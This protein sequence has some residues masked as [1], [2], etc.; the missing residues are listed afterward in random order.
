MQHEIVSPEAWLAARK[1]HLAKEKEF[2]RLRDQLSRRAARSCPG[3]GSTSG[4]AFDGPDGRRTLP[5]LFDGRSQL[6]VYHFMLGPGWERGLQRAA[7]SSPTTST[8]RSCISRIATSRWSR[9]RARRWPRSRR[10]SSAWAGA[11]RGSLRY[12]SDFNAD[13]HVSFTQGASWPRGKVYYNYGMTEFPS[14]EAPGASVFYKDEDGAV[15]HTYSAYARG[16]D[17]LVGTYNWLD[18][19]PKGRD[20][21]ALPWTMAW[22]RH[23]DRYDVEPR[24]GIMSRAWRCRNRDLPNSSFGTSISRLP[25]GPR[26]IVSRIQL[27]LVGR[28]EDE[29]KRTRT[30]PCSAT[31]SSATTTKRRSTR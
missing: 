19:A 31:P 18:L 9:S 21:A 16:L 28:T 1:A 4:Y 22:V 26:H 23:H 27:D 7:R 30:T 15:F 29:P 3:H 10:S 24:A 12:G 13:F 20:E 8:A 2:T 14:E 6:I 5:E 11:S 17:M 25:D